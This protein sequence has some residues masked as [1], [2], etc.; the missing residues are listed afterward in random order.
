MLE[1]A[2]VVEGYVMCGVCALVSVPEVVWVTGVP[3]TPMVGLLDI[4]VK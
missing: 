3:V 4:V 1:T 2:T